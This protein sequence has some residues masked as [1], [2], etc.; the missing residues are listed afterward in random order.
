MQHDMCKRSFQC[1]QAIKSACHIFFYNDLVH[2]VH[3]LRRNR[4]RKLHGFFSKLQCTHCPSLTIWQE[5]F[6]DFS[7]HSYSDLTH[8]DKE[9][10][11][12]FPELGVFFRSQCHSS[13]PSGSVCS[14]NARQA[15]EHL[16][17]YTTPAL[18]KQNADL[19]KIKNQ[20]KYS[21]LDE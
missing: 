1:L 15:E 3:I 11:D 6:P 4:H 13:Q 9:R 21:H 18:R 20:F 5:V 14:H 12:A 19:E 2:N 17:A 7:L 16:C 8:E 10:V